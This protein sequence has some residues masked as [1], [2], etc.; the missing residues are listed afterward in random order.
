MK[1]LLKNKLIF[2]SFNTILLFLLLSVFPFSIYKIM[3]IRQEKE[4][5]QT[6]EYVKETNSLKFNQLSLQGT[7]PHGFL[8]T[9]K[10]QYQVNRMENNAFN[11]RSYLQSEYRE[12]NSQ[13]INQLLNNYN[14]YWNFMFHV[15]N[16]LKQKI[17]IDKKTLDQIEIVYGKK[18]VKALKKYEASVNSDIYATIGLYYF[19]TAIFLLVFYSR[20]NRDRVKEF[21]YLWFS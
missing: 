9:Q 21:I 5:T 15:K 7:P 6:S 3:D 17:Y 14:E 13:E 16:N 2:I 10:L 11:V 18:N 1:H 4:M 19:F 8:Q 12:T 20:K